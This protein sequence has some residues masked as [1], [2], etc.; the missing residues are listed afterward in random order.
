MQS[1]KKTLEQLEE[2]KKQNE[3]I[4]TQ[5]AAGY[6]KEQKSAEV[7]NATFVQAVK[8][9]EEGHPVDYTIGG[10]GVPKE[11]SSGAHCKEQSSGCRDEVEEH[12]GPSE[13]YY[14]ESCRALNKKKKEKQEQQS[15]TLGRFK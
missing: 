8:R 14:N 1:Q 15:I 9:G 5:C 13:S 2:D 10:G 11:A 6:T 3:H 4:Y 7:L 12:H